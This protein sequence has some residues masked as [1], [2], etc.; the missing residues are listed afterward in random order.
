MEVIERMAIPSLLGL[1]A[2]MLGYFGNRMVAIVDRLVVSMGDHETR[3]TA[4][5]T[6][7]Q[8]GEYLQ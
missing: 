4:L 2:S 8:I 1:V 7:Q 5:E 6:L 3:L